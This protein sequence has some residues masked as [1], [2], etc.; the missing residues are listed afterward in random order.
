MRHHKAHRKL[1]KKA[2]PR[3]AL[4]RGLAGNLIVRGKITTT[5]AKARELRP[6]IEKLTTRARAGTLASRRLVLSRLGNT[7]YTKQLCDI[8]APRY[9]KR[10]GGYT[11]IIKLGRRVSDGS[12]KA[13]IE[14]V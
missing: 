9:A 1:S 5:E 13:M 7:A 12:P 14:F 11:R 4:L 8:I 3:R 10:A 2:G 6:F